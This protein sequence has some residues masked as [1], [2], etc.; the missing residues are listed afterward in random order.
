MSKPV[1]QASHGKGNSSR[2][3]QRVRTSRPKSSDEPVPVTPVVTGPAAGNALSGLIAVINLQTR[4]YKS[5]VSRLLFGAIERSQPGVRLWNGAGDTR[6]G[7]LVIGDMPSD[8][9]GADWQRQTALA[10]Q[11]VIPV[12]DD[13]LAA[14]AAQWLL[15]RLAAGGRPDLAEAAVV[16]AIQTGRD[17]KLARRIVRHFR[18]RTA[19]VI[20][21]RLR[22]DT[23][24]TGNDSLCRPLARAVLR[25]MEQTDRDLAVRDYKMAVS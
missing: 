12:P 14:N 22:Q 25:E 23:V 4:S 13:V 15:D 19:K 1:V 24:P 9:S 16:V 10:D 11:L 2:E 20:R 17:R 8:L 18:A 6:P 7:G 5:V 21:V 3:E